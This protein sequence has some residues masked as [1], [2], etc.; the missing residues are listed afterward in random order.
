[1]GTQK[2]III[3][4]K[5]MSKNKQI[6]IFS[7]IGL[8]VLGAVAAILLLT[9]PK[10][11]PDTNE[12]TNV[13][14]EVD[15]RL[16]LTEKT[17]ADIVSIHVKNLNDEYDIV[18]NGKDWT[19]LGIEKATI[20]TDSL[21]ALAANVSAMT[22]DQVVEENAADLSKYGLTA[23]D[24][25]VT[26]DYGDEKFSFLVGIE[27]PASSSTVYFCEKDKNTVYTYK[28]TKVSGFTADRFSFVSTAAMPAYDQQAG[29]EVT[30]FTIQRADLEEPIV[31]EQIPAPGEDEIAVF[32][33]ELTS[34][35]NA[36]ADLTNAPNFI[37]SLFGLTADKVA[38]FGME[39]QD[40]EISGIN[41]PNCVFTLETTFKTYTITLGNAVAEEVADENGN[42]TTRIAGFYGMSSEVPDTLFLFNVDSI[43]AFSIQAE[44]II[45]RLFLMPYIYSLDTVEYSDCKGQ[46][47]TLGFETIKGEGEDGADIHNHY[48]NGEPHDEQQIKNMYQYLIAASGD[49]IYMG[50]EKGELL[51]TVTYNYKDKNESSDVVKFYSSDEDRKVIIN[52][53]GDNLFKTK[54]IYINQ[55]YSNAESFLKGGEIVLTY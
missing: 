6:L 9:A 7:V 54:Q 36:Y 18:K 48:L 55:L 46:K 51:A 24:A 21:S 12:D 35:Y 37:Y 39:E 34:P 49:D 14:E 2:K 29:E 16:V 4:G 50:E 28:K 26:V 38:W 10:E 47:F 1:M 41:N 45:S 33:Y 3:K 30:K 23:P 11:Q 22:A 42:V 53:N 40:Y 20:L 43:P 25:E 44:S 17:E 13:Q 5:N 52:V 19:I 32:S 8:L 15:E 31:I 27:T